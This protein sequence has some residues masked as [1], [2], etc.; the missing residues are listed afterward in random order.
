MSTTLDQ[1]VEQGRAVS[2]IRRAIVADRVHHAW[3][4]HGPAGVGKRTA[5]VA[6]G[7]E[8]LAPPSGPERERI[9]AMAIEGRHPDL[10]VVTR[11]LAA[12]SRDEKVRAGVQRNIAKEVVE[13]FLIEPAQR[14]AVMALGGAV[15]KVF[16]VEGAEHLWE[17]AQN[18]L[19]KTLE[20]PPPGTVIILVTAG[21]ER[22][23]PTIRSRCQRVAFTP[24][25]PGAVRTWSERA[26]P[27]ID[28][29][30]REWLLGVCDGSP[31]EF[32]A[33]AE[34]GAAEWF[35][36]LRPQLD[37]LMQGSYAADLGPLLAKRMDDRAK[38]LAGAGENASKDAANRAVAGLLFRIL[39]AE[40]RRRL[41]EELSQGK[42][43]ARCL[44]AI[45]ALRE[46][47]RALDT[48]VN[49]AFAFERLSVDMA[50]A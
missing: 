43:P 19:L 36:E 14:S 23:L 39:A 5:A 12:V 30:Q 20:E 45:D 37:R 25:T 15:S 34:A 32:R 41:R 13:E 42:S 1:L 40:F 27:E 10:H 9:R 47:E 18:S 38:A 3:L 46:S 29:E 26:H 35:E 33:M 4:F 49:A 6:M 22:L 48:N 24:L 2:I 11:E 50:R 21:E 28:P 16:I 8:L 7:I 31:G 17:P 44:R